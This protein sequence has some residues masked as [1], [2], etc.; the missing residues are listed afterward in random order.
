[1]SR[2]QVYLQC[3]FFFL[4]RFVCYLQNNLNQNS[5]S[6]KLI[7]P[8]SN[9]MCENLTFCYI[10]VHYLYHTISIPKQFFLCTY[11]NLV[12]GDFMYHKSVGV[13]KAIIKCFR[14]RVARSSTL[15]RVLF[16]VIMIVLLDSFLK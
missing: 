14:G 7:V 10:W 9:Q 4:K 6:Q 8:P 3:R 11:V 16:K 15:I 1:M 12:N 2:L 5:I 13:I